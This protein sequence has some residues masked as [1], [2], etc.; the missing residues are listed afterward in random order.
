V[1]ALA[2]LCTS[3]LLAWGYAAD[4][5]TPLTPLERIIHAARVGDPSGLSEVCDPKGRVDSDARR[6]CEAR[7]SDPRAWE[8]FRSWF[9]DAKVHGLVRGG[10]DDDSVVRVALAIGPDHRRADATVVRRGDRW[11]LSQL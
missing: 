4:E 7:P 1:V 9:A 11:Y 8:L 5:Q 10:D 2:V 6:V 3:G